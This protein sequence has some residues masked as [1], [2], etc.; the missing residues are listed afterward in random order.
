MLRFFILTV[1]LLVTSQFVA[2]QA[3]QRPPDPP[4]TEQQAPAP[5]NGTQFFIQ[6]ITELEF[7]NYE[8]AI[9]LLLQAREILGSK[10]GINYSLAQAYFNTRDLVNAALYGKMAVE[11]EPENVFYRLL[12]AEIYERSGRNQ[13]TIDELKAILEFQPANVEVL[14]ELARVKTRHGQRLEA[15]RIY[16][17]ILNITG[18]DLYVYML[19]FRNLVNLNMIQDA[20]ERLLE[21]LEYDER[22]VS[23]LQ[24]AAQFYTEQQQYDKALQVTK[25]AFELNPADT[26]TIIL[27]SD[28]L[29]RDRRWE[30]AAELVQNIIYDER[31]RDVTKVEMVQYFYGQ[32]TQNPANMSLRNA[33]DSLIETLLQ[34]T[35]ELGH[36]HALAADYFMFIQDDDRLLAALKETNRLAPDLDS[37]WQQRMQILLSLG[38]Y[39][40]VVSIGK[41][42]DDYI[43]DD[44]V[45]LFL[46][47]NA[48][49]I[50][51]EYE[52]AVSTLTR[53]SELPANRELRSF[54]F[55][56]L[57]DALSSQKKW[58]EAFE[59]YESSIRF[60]GNNYTALNNF[61]YYL[62]LQE[63]RLEE[64][65]EM[66]TKAVQN[67]PN[68]AAFLDTLGWIYYKMGEYDDALTYIQA[69]VDTG[70]ASAV[71]LEHLG[72][73]YSALGNSDEAKLWWKRALEKDPEKSHLLEKIN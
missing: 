5:G 2:L 61:A 62:S 65:L 73:V 8:E 42:A 38:E 54:V 46:M 50:L 7:E 11:E 67:E 10:S 26:E 14:M 53:A 35:P 51:S 64:A 66:A 12:L 47:G 52:N 3:Q 58:D 56:V 32:L 24:M 41:K 71:V 63:T 18:P 16:D 15:N 31:V 27:L 49:L 4:T 68:N 25:R 45:I 59:A 60:F 33:T 13:A 39:E 34:E 57:G 19:R 48:Y 70:D 44:T 55:G 6:G 69:S 72:D 36:S 23:I 20:E 43:P 29:I 17:R 9:K 22:N 40:E 37:A 28:L 30:E 1:L 21:I